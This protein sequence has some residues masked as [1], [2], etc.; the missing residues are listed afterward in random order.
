[1]EFILIKIMEIDMKEYG[2]TTL[3]KE[4]ENIFML[5]GIFMKVNSKMDTKMEEALS[6]GELEKNMKENLEMI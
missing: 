5:M 6:T 2:K 3:K 1:M 4:K